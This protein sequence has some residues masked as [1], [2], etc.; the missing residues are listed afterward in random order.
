MSL[1]PTWLQQQ[2][3]DIT[4][5]RP[6]G[7]GG[8]KWVFAGD[9]PSDGPVVLKLFHP[10]S[11]PERGLREVQGVLET[12]SHRVPRVYEAGVV[13]SQI[14][15]MIWVRE[16]RLEGENLR[17]RLQRGPMDPRA[18]L[19][20]ALHVL[21][22]LVAAESARIVHRDVKPE[23]IFA[24]TGG[25]FWLLD[26]GLSRHLDKESLTATGLPFGV[27]TFG[28]SPA[29]QFR[30]RKDDID[31]RADLFALGVTLYECV[32][33]VNPFRAG[34]RDAGEIL[35]R[36]ETTPLPPIS[37]AV[38]SSHQFRDLVTALTRT[39]RD[40]RLRTAAEALQWI[41]EICA[42]EGMS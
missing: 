41:R 3:P 22:A 6:I 38:G 1:D 37:R 28:Y 5:L 36:V 39:R 12:G 25:C 24:D 33:R 9:H 35:R 8:Q 19:R 17:E 31:A 27:G 21:E 32:E 10:Q 34:A 11:D 14:G 18:V 13:P 23:N 26:F 30:N 2:F 15:P 7:Q 29:E 16:Q 40:Q 4:G 20:L 42:A